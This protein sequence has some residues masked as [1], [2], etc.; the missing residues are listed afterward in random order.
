MGDEVLDAAR[1]PFTR[2]RAVEGGTAHCQTA[3]LTGGAFLTDVLP[4]E[5]HVRSLAERDR[6]IPLRDRELILGGVIA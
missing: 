5:G 6:H 3:T 2:H 4:L 1:V